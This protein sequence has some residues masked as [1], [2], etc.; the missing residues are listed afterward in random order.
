MVMQNKKNEIIRS[1][2]LASWPCQH[3]ISERAS[4]A[5]RSA[6]S[7]SD[8][9]GF[10]FQNLTISSTNLF[11]ALLNLLQ[12]D[13][14]ATGGNRSDFIQLILAGQ[15]KKK[16]SEASRSLPG[17]ASIIL[18]SDNSCSILFRILICQTDA[19]ARDVV[20]HMI[21]DFML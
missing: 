5:A 21:S 18:I 1:F 12:N 3:P 13:D 8:S 19:H 14:F 17:H 15:N 9:P 20:F 4:A 7:G 10:K 16:S 2:A 11:S 6:A